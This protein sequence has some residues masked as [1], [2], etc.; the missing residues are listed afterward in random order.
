[1]RRENRGGT[2]RKEKKREK[3]LKMMWL[4]NSEDGRSDE[5]R[6]DTKEDMREMYEWRK[7]KEERE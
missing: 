2:K 4:K 3:S 1:M 7:E 6:K 5:G